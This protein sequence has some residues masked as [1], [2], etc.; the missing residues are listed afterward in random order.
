[1]S[2]KKQFFLT[3]WLKRLFRGAHTEIDAL[4]E[5]QLQTPLRTAIRNFREKKSAMFGLIVFIL[6]L[7]F[8]LVGPYIWHLDLSYA[9]STMA[10]VRPG[11]DLLNVPI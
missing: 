11:R 7:I 6:I 1:M 9:D 8:V 5:E 10:N 2:S 3:R 4:A